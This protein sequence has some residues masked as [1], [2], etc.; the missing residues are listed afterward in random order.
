MC[1]CVWRGANSLTVSS[2]KEADLLVLKMG[3]IQAGIWTLWVFP[4]VPSPSLYL[5]P[6]LSPNSSWNF[7]KLDAG[8]IP[9]EQNL[10]LGETLSYRTRPHPPPASELKASGSRSGQVLGGPAWEG[11]E[12]LPQAIARLH[13]PRTPIQP[14]SCFVVGVPGA[15]SPHPHPVE[16]PSLAV[17][18]TTCHHRRSEKQHQP[19]APAS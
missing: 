3:P 11:T 4:G 8:C 13:C 18:D 1:V 2:P 14:E 16:E 9:Q 10:G 15:P 17:E 19:Q 6:S 5:C 12:L 7:V